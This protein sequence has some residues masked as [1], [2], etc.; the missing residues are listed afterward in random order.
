MQELCFLV[1]L[2]VGDMQAQAK[3]FVH[4][5]LTVELNS[6]GLSNW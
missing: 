6:T 2:E 1:I 5:R 4:N 3:P